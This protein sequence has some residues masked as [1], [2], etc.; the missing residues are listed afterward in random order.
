MLLRGCWKGLSMVKLEIE[1]DE[2]VARDF[3]KLVKRYGKHGKP[4]FTPEEWV[5]SVLVECAWDYDMITERLMM[6]PD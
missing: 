6:A 2:D 3:R 5:L 1:V 4:D